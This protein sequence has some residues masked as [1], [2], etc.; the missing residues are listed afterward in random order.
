M[1]ITLKGS[2]N[3]LHSIVNINW[4]PLALTIAPKIDFSKA[5]EEK[6]II[7]SRPEIN[8]N[9][10][11]NPLPTK[12]SIDLAN[13]KMCWLVLK[14]ANNFPTRAYDGGS[15]YHCVVC[16]SCQSFQRISIKNSFCS[17]PYKFA[18]KRWIA[19]WTP[20]NKKSLAQ[21]GIE[22]HLKDKLRSSKT[23]QRLYLLSSQHVPS[24]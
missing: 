16:V 18:G 22:K 11:N 19:S 4:Y 12:F 14:V 8:L 23:I 6:K 1:G 2:G 9:D 20:A 7:L 5:D 17:D 21:K 15:I 3:F 13:L 10:S 24:R